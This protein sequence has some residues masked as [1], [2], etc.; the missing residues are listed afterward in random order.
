LPDGSELELR[1]GALDDE[2]RALAGEDVQTLLL[3][4]GPTLAAAFVAG[5]L[6][7][8]LRLF[9]APVFAGDGPGLT[10]PLPAP[11]RL[12]RLQARQVGDD[13]LLTAYVHEP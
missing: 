6:V 7:D 4:G 3:E 5:D 13:V 8:E 9:V 1:P 2:L 11:V 12:Q 10:A